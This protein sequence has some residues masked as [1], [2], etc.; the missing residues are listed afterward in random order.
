MNIWGAFP[1]FHFVWRKMSAAGSPRAG[2]GS[3]GERSTALQYRETGGAVRPRLAAC[4][5]DGI[6]EAACFS[7][8]KME[9]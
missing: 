2:I 7:Q 6:L 5:H 9:Q 3:H 8:V 4:P 1:A